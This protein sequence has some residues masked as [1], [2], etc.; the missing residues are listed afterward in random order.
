[1]II[2][3]CRVSDAKDLDE[4]NRKSL[5][6]NYPLDHWNLCLQYQSQ[7]CFLAEEDGKP[8]GYCLAIAT[9]GINGF[10]KCSGMIVSIAVLEQFRRKGIAKKLLE[11]SLSRL[12]R[13]C[14]DVSLHVRISNVNAQSLYKQ[15]GFVKTRLIPKYYNDGEDA[16]EMK[17]EIKSQNYH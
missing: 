17:L 11:E 1:M 9:N 8:V 15:M 16:Y 7:F 14:S 6:E 4:I 10:T 12:K 5:P 13:N 2:R 3:Q